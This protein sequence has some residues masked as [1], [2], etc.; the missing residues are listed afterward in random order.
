MP[1]HGCPPYCSRAV[2]NWGSG[3]LLV[4]VMMGL[5]RFGGVTR[6]GLAVQ[7]RPG[8]GLSVLRQAV[9][10]VQ[11]AVQLNLGGQ[12]PAV[13]VR[14]PQP[15]PGAHRVPDL[16]LRV[17]LPERLQAGHLVGVPG[18][19]HGA[20]RLTRTPARYPGGPMLSSAS[21]RTA[22]ASSAWRTSVTS[23]DRMPCS[24]ASMASMASMAV[25]AARRASGAGSPSGR[26]SHW[27]RAAARANVGSPS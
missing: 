19:G 12:D 22:A 8:R 26:T 16:Y 9:E 5:P 20:T 24:A 3:R 25:F 13:P 4:S 2:D 10:P 15:A 14:A 23:R 11:E 7:V 6:P 1:A 27:A 18:P 17:R 21:A